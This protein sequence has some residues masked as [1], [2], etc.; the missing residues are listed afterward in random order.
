MFDTLHVLFTASI[1]YW[2]KVHVKKYI[3]FNHWWTPGFQLT[4]K[5]SERINLVSWGIPVFRFFLALILHLPTVR[6]NIILT[7]TFKSTSGLF[8]LSI[9]SKIKEGVM[10]RTWSAKNT[11]ERG[12][13]YTKF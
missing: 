8:P 11:F 5:P 7:S 9:S 6:F 1:I 10:D 12:E 3:S 2:K 13:M 4:P